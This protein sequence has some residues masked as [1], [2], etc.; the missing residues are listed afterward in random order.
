LQPGQIVFTIMARS[1]T[2]EPNRLAYH[3]INWFS[4][5]C[6]WKSAGILVRTPHSTAKLHKR[7]RA[8]QR[9]WRWKMLSISLELP[10]D[11]SLQWN[12]KEKHWRPVKQEQPNT[13][14]YQSAE[15]HKKDDLWTATVIS[16]AMLIL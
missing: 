5:A 8:M 16:G 4:K 14:L 9:T 2:D 13:E 10:N 1:A 15:G 7:Q 3:N 11:S 12:K 6:G